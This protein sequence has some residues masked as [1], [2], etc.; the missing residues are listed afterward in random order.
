MHFTEKTSLIPEKTELDFWR[1]CGMLTIKGGIHHEYRTTALFYG[2]VQNTE[3]FHCRTAAIYYV[4]HAVPQY[5]VAEGRTGDKAVL[6][7]KRNGVADFGGKAD[8]AGIVPLAER[9]ENTI[10]RVRNRGRG[11]AGEMTI[12]ISDEQQFPEGLIGAVN[13]LIN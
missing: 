11:L 5:H 8:P 7:G 12:A 6:P 4:A 9:Y 3:L 10:Q 1:L 2:I 13:S